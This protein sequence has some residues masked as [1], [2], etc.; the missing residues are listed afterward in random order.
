VWVWARRSLPLQPLPWSDFFERARDVPV[1]AVGTVRVYESG[2]PQEGK[3]LFVLVHGAGLSAQSWATAAVRMCTERERETPSHLG[4]TRPCID[5][6]IGGGGAHS[7]RLLSWPA[8][9]TAPC[10][11]L[12]VA[13]TVRATWTGLWACACVC[14]YGSGWV[15]SV[16]RVCAD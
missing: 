16:E 12:T 15:W 5:S 14:I 7:R 13:A 3:S 1:P 4:H 6:H 9:A 2:Q 10:S 8:T 11:L